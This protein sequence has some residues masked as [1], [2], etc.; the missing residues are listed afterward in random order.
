MMG[1][2]TI[3]IAVVRSNSKSATENRSS[4][5]NQAVPKKLRRAASQ[6]SAGTEIGK[7]KITITINDN[8]DD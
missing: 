1:L 8:D 6:T 3:I 2:K 7:K 4:A 5:N